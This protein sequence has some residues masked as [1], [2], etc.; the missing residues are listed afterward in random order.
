M[1]RLDLEIIYY[2]AGE[3]SC[4]QKTE[5]DW[6]IGQ[7]PAQFSRAT[8]MSAFSIERIGHKHKP[9]PTSM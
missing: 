3:S 8:V 6:K 5:S 2:L 9:P 1:T 4:S 7:L